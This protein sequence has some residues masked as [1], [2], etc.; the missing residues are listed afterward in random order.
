MNT[1][2][3]HPL[4]RLETVDYGGPKGYIDALET[5]MKAID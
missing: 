3:S 1:G 2:N 5:F 4:M